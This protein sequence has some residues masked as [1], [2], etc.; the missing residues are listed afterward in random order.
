MAAPVEQP[1]DDFPAGVIGIG[2]QEHR[3]RQLQGGEQEQQFVEQRATVAVGEHQTFV[4]PRRQRHGLKARA[5]L[6]QQRERLAGM[7]HDER[8]LC[9]GVGSLMEGLDGRHLTARLRLFQPI[10]QQHEATVD[11][12]HAGMG[13]QDDP[14][15]GPRQGVHT[16][17]GA[18]EEIQEA[19]IAARLEPEGPH[20]A[21]DPAEVP[22]DRHGGERHRQP[23]KGALARTRRTQLRDDEPPVGPQK[24]A[25]KL[26][27]STV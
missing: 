20:E 17:R 24:Q 13:R 16:E 12:L 23:Q 11:P 2:D 22:A 6:D 21:G 14:H 8:W 27:S 1:G 5:D 26:T 4:N 15:P 19:A 7:A 25:E 10:G 3:L 18:V 9:I